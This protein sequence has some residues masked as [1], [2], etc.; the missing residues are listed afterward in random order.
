MLQHLT[1]TN[2]RVLHKKQATVEDRMN[3][4]NNNIYMLKC[5]LKFFKI[6]LAEIG[7]NPFSYAFIT[8]CDG[9]LEYKKIMITCF[10]LHNFRL[11]R[12]AIE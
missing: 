2:A 1:L 10:H 4:C 5:Y 11:F 12:L 3:S 7:S 9:V 8:L 6:V